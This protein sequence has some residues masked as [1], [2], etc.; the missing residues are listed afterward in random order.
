VDNKARSADAINI[1]QLA[2]AGSDLSKLHHIEF[3]L[4]FPSQAAAETAQSRLVSFAFE[5][6]IE[7]GKTA[8]QWVIHASKTMFPVEAD[9]MGLRDKLNAIAAEEHGVYEGWRADIVK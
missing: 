1:D 9:L 8:G 7:R 2:K 5:T 6:R 3:L 4:H